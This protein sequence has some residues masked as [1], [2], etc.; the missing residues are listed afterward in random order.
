MAQSDERVKISIKHVSTHL[1]RLVI[2]APISHVF[3]SVSERER[4]RVCENK[5]PHIAH[6]PFPSLFLS[7]HKRERLKFILRQ[8]R[9]RRCCYCW[10]VAI[11]MRKI[12][13]W[14]V[15]THVNLA[16][17]HDMRVVLCLPTG[18]LLTHFR[19]MKIELIKREARE[20]KFMKFTTASEWRRSL[21]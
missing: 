3:G 7:R 5:W 18:S 15:V 9:R 20:K 16:V 14:C 19:L 4:E 8:L 17:S 2:F 1:A 10:K 11:N 13:A 12:W 21:D 6:E